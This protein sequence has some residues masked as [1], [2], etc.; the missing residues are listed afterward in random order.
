M[1]R[2]FNREVK[3]GRLRV[4][5]YLVDSKNGKGSKPSVE[6]EIRKKEDEYVDDL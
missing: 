6:E 5:D 2:Y 1:E 3:A 4:E